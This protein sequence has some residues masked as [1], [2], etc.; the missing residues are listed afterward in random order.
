M[1]YGSWANIFA[2][3][4]YGISML[5]SHIYSIAGSDKQSDKNLGDEIWLGQ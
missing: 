3:A 4:Y 2:G 5:T 1:R